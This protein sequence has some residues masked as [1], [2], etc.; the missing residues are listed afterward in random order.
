MEQPFIIKYKPQT[1]DDFELDN[2]IKE[3][4]NFL[5]EINSINILL[6]G[7]SGSGKTTLADIITKQY[8]KD[9]LKLNNYSNN[10]ILYINTLKEQGIHYYRNEVKTFCQTKN[11]DNKKKKFLVI[12]DIDLINEQG[13]Q[14]FRN[15]LDKYHNNVNFIC[16]CKNLQKVIESLQSRQTIIQLNYLN[17]MQINKIFNLVKNKENLNIDYESQKLMISLSNHSIRRM[18]NYLDK[19]RLVNSHINYELAK[20]ICTDISYKLFQE[21]T[22]L[23]IDKNNHKE[24][25]FNRNF[26]KA[27][28]ILYEIYDNG[29]SVIDILDNY[30]KYI[31]QSKELLDNTKFIIIKL[32]CK[33]ISVFYEIHEEK[34][35]LSLLTN[36]LILSLL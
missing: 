26:I 20:E 1:I 10:N 35:E 24:A 36:N 17:E 9:K 32:L 27:N 22:K 12:D 23:I 29:Y 28:N 30:F 13:Q 11:T 31:K 33:Y 4:I 25:D 34:I 7:D 8:Y 18:L 3:I 21:Y 16:T 14:V 15:C 2:K 19:C 5:I 6:I